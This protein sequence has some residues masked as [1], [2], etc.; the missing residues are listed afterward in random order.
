M[1]KTAKFPPSP[2][3]MRAV[4]TDKCDCGAVCDMMVVAL[5]DKSVHIIFDGPTIHATFCTPSGLNVADIVPE[6]FPVPV[7]AE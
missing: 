4:K 7:S 5:G 1:S 3:D 2:S 6:L